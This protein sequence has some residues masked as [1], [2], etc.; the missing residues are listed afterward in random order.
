MMT[1]LC[2]SAIMGPLVASMPCIEAMAV[3][4]PVAR[5]SPKPLAPLCSKMHLE[6]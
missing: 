1:M 6:A 2:Y 4:S 3:C 5:F